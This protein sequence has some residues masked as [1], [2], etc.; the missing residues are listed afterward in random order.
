L[1]QLAHLL[2]N[3]NLLSD[4]HQFEVFKNQFKIQLNDYWE[5]HYNFGKQGK[6]STPNLT[7]AF[8]DLILINV[9]VPYVFSLARLQD[10]ETLKLST[11]ELLGSI[12][13]ERNSII[14]KWGKLNVEVKSAFD[15][16]AL[17]E[18]KNEFC[19]NHQCLNCRIGYNLLKN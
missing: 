8:I 14:N 2:V 4:S 3:Q 16:Q 13:P 11:F 5:I 19:Y 6:K 17:I 18:Q 9:Y 12:K 7:Q 15:T 10:N 1:T